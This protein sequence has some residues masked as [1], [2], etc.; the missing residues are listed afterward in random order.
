MS[1]IVDGFGE[2]YNDKITIEWDDG[3]VK[4]PYKENNDIKKEHVIVLSSAKIIKVSKK[5]N[6]NWPASIPVKVD[7]GIA[8][9]DSYCCCTLKTDQNPASPWTITPA[10]GVNAFCLIASSAD[11]D[12][13]IT[14]G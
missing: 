6:C 9:I 2:T 11:P 7:K 10:V 1:K 13:T 14:I 4:L 3:K 5:E 12:A 8:K